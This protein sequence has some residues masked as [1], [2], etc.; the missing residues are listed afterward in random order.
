MSSPALTL[1]HEFESHS[2]NGCLRLLFSCCPVYV[3]ALRRADLSSKSP[4]NCL[5]L[6]I[7]ELILNENRPQEEEDQTEFLIVVSYLLPLET[8]R[9]M[10]YTSSK[11]FRSESQDYICL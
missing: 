10:H 11:R 4:S 6:I 7:S 9:Q 5:R 1:D 2:R 3:A 8:Q